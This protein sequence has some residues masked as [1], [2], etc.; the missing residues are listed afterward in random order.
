MVKAAQDHHGPT[1]VTGPKLALHFGVVRQHVD[2]LVQKGVIEKR[3]DNLF[4]QDASRLKYLTYLRDDP[5]GRRPC[6]TLGQRPS[7]L[8][9]EPCCRTPARGCLR[10]P[11][12]PGWSHSST[13]SKLVG[14]RPVWK[15]SRAAARAS[16][17][18]TSVHLGN[19]EYPSP[20]AYPISL[21][22]LR[23]PRLNALDS[24]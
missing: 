5:V 7:R 8:L 21:S 1:L 9:S 6:T 4:D 17:L 14:R 10:R 15:N 22:L 12:R 23:R 2:Q 19:S 13:Q 18:D 3:P 20:Y 24:P 11:D 16:S